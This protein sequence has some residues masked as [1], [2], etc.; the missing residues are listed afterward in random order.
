MAFNC[1]LPLIVGPVSNTITHI[2]NSITPLQPYWPFDQALKSI[3]RVPKLG[4]WLTYATKAHT[5]SATHRLHLSVT[6]L[7]IVYSNLLSHY[8]LV[9]SASNRFSVFHL[10]VLIKLHSTSA[11]QSAASLP[12][13]RLNQIL[14]KGCLHYTL[15]SLLVKLDRTRSKDTCHDF[16]GSFFH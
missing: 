6:R 5:F 9:V 1:D 16:V 4:L 15:A 8:L 10:R 7:A 13:G 12:F 11:H 3:G 2:N 14:S